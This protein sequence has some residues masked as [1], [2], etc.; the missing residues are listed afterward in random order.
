MNEQ[1]RRSARERLLV[2]LLLLAFCGFTARLVQLQVFEHA[3]WKQVAERQS[4]TTVY[5]KAAR[6]EIRDS[7]GWPLA[8]TLP[9]T[10]AIGYRPT[11]E[12]EPAEVA[13]AIA[14]ILGMKERT[15]R[16]KMNSSRFVY[17]AR[18]VDLQAKQSLESLHLKCLQF[19]EEPRRSYPGKTQAASLVGFVDVDGH[20]RE[21]I[22]AS[23]DSVLS[24]EG[25]REQSRVDALRKESA[26]LMDGY[27]D[28]YFGANVN[29]SIDARLQTIVEEQL[30]KDFEH[31][32][33]E[34]AC[35]ILVKPQT[36]DILA[37][38]TLPCFD[39]NDLAK[40]TAA[41]RKCWPITDVYE[42][43]S[44]FKILPVIKALETGKLH[45]SSIIDCEGGAYRV[46]GATI[47]DAHPYGALT[48]DEVLAYSSNIGAAKIGAHFTPAEIYDK[49]RA[50]GFGN[51][52][53]VELAGEQA[54][55]VPNPKNWSGPTQANLC[56]GHGISCTALQLVMAYACI[57]NDGL[58]MK[59]RLIRSVDFADGTR[60]EVPVEPVRRVVTPEVAGD[61]TDMLENVIAY[62]TAKRSAVDGIAIAAKTGT[63][64]KVDH[65]HHTYFDK[66]FVSSLVG[67]FPADNPEYTLLIL[68]D[69]PRG[70]Y[71]GASVAGPAFKNIIDEMK[72]ATFVNADAHALTARTDESAHPD[73]TAQVALAQ[74]KPVAVSGETVTAPILP[75]VQGEGAALT[76][77][78]FV[79]GWPLRKALE[80]FSRRRLPCTLSGTRVV[81]TQEPPA[82]TLVAAGTLCRVTGIVD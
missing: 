48:M 26:P 19:D 61:L 5:Q 8:V 12:T 43:G 20:G 23:L 45:R 47:H 49:I 46:K 2:V 58:L 7:N 25:Y 10:Y 18:R 16:D 65:V 15:L 29:L 17:L 14:P 28:E 52:T 50:F 24:G 38:A 82:G 30:R 40:S 62:G 72:A 56:Y 67:Y 36:G 32:D 60:R 69:D 53:F 35:A 34:R 64:Q 75:Q 76:S 3:A 63:A 44:T 73:R 1:S 51:L 39:P 22:E 31:R 81:V 71:F 11:A 59:P 4:I 66:R 9:L 68:V 78:P 37:L 55:I 77:V 54:G 13:S 70:E 27:P 42:P 33:F 41:E 80:E 79:L 6:G 74:S 57:A 21:G